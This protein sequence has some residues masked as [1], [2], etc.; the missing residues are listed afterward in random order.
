M[1]YILLWQ[2]NSLIW[3]ISFNKKNKK[4]KDQ[5]AKLREEMEEASAQSKREREQQMR[6]LTDM[7]TV[8]FD[9]N[10]YEAAMA[11]L[12]R[13]MENLTKLYQNWVG[14][15]EFFGKIESFIEIAVIKNIED[16]NKLSQKI[17]SGEMKITK[18]IE[19]KIRM[20]TRNVMYLQMSFTYFF[21]VF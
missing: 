1:I 8:T 18:N 10:N 5:L 4:I 21:I 3:Y 14:L 13:G 9:K 17:L 6:I 12:T 11:T 19:N 7:G 2:F 20:T 16:L 15:Q